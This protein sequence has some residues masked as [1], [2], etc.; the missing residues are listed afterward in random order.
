VLF[1]Y[2]FGDFDLSKPPNPLSEDL[3]IKLRS[4]IDMLMSSRPHR[5]KDKKILNLIDYGQTGIINDA[6]GY[7]NDAYDP[8]NMTYPF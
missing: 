4:V 6:T 7:F 3:A 2:S 5:E 1:R 8:D